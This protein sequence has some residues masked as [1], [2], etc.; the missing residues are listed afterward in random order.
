MGKV[1]IGEPSRNA[2]GSQCFKFQG[3]DHV[4]V[5][6]PSRNLLVRKVDVHEIETVI[7]ELTSS[8]TDSDDDICSDF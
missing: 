3:Y 7:Y 2:E 8:T 5:Q 1:V 6:C 4:V